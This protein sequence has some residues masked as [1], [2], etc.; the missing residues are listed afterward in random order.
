MNSELNISNSAQKAIIDSKNLDRLS[1]FNWHMSFPSK[2]LYR[3]YRNNDKMVTVSLASEVMNR[4][5]L[6]FDHKDRNSFN[7]LEENLRPAGASQNGINRS[8][9]KGIFT[10]KYKGVHWY[11]RDKKWRASI[12]KNYKSIDLGLHIK[13]EDAAKA[14]DK[15][16]KE[17]FGEF[18]YLNFP[19]EY[20][21]LIKNANNSNTIST[22]VGDFHT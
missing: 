20:E 21:Q 3:S 19:K 17:L 13:E 16:A 4:P 12:R 15:K 9:F 5:D 11:A 1:K 7:N 18:A 22:A 14:Y 8:K 10:S 6:M 2:N